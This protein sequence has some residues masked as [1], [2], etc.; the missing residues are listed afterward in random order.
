MSF[1]IDSALSCVYSKST[2]N[3]AVADGAVAFYLDHRVSVRVSNFTYGTRCAIEF[4]KNDEQHKLR[5]VSV[6]PRPSG[7]MV[8]PNAFSAILHKVFSLW[9]VFG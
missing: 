4:N 5:A 6:V 2:R 9:L 1:E 8:L 7:R 3:K